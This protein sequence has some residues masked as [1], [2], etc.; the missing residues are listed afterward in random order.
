MGVSSSS[1]LVSTKYRNPLSLAP[2]GFCA[3]WGLKNR[4]AR[5]HKTS[6]GPNRDHSETKIQT[7]KV[8]VTHFDN[9]YDQKTLVFDPYPE[10]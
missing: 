2:S 10:F 6:Q 4:E 7:Q 8:G 5:R 1:L 9:G 3:F